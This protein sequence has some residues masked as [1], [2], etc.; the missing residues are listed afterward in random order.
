MVRSPRTR[1]GGAPGLM[2][3]EIGMSGDFAAAESG[4]SDGED[5][6]VPG[7]TR[8]GE[9]EFVFGELLRPEI[10][11]EFFGLPPLTLIPGT[12]APLPLAPPAL[13]PGLVEFPPVPPLPGVPFAEP[14][15]TP[16]RVPSGEMRSEE[17]RVGKEC[18]SRWSPYH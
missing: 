5:D 12:T 4:L 16:G 6:T 8:K 9:R 15:G 1:S 14:P 11:G 7:A 10:P 3:A 2:R 18:R 13:P 17:R